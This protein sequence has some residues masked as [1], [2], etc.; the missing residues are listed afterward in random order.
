LTAGL[1]F[2]I[3]LRGRTEIIKRSVMRVGINFERREYWLFFNHHDGF[4][5]PMILNV[6]F[7]N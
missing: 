6:Y 3:S 2:V 1:I 4:L 5:K 7:L